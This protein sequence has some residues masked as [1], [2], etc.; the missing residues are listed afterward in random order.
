MKHLLIALVMLISVSVILDPSRTAAD[1]VW[2][3]DVSGGSSFTMGC[4]EEPSAPLNISL[5]AETSLNVNALTVSWEP[6]ETT[7]EIAQ[8]EYKLDIWGDGIR[9][10]S[11]EELPP[12]D[13]RRPAGERERVTASIPL[14]NYGS[15]WG[16]YYSFTSENLPEGTYTW[17]LFVRDQFGN[18]VST[19]LQ[20]VRIDRT[21][22]TVSLMVN[23]SPF[24]RIDD[25]IVI[26]NPETATYQLIAND[27]MPGSGIERTEYRVDGGA[28]TV[29]TSFTLPEGALVTLEYRSLDRAGNSSGIREEEIATD[30]EA[31]DAI[32]TLAA[33]TGFNTADLS[34]K[35]PG[36]NNPDNKVQNYEIFY[37]PA[38]SGGFDS[39]LTV[40]F[41]GSPGVE[42]SDQ[43]VTVTGLTPNTMYFAV[44]FST[45]F[46]GNRSGISNVAMF[47]TD[48]GR[49]Y[50]TDEIEFETVVYEGSVADKT[51]HIILRNKTAQALDMTGMSLKMQ[52][53]SGEATLP[54]SF[55]GVTI[56]GNGSVSVAAQ[57]ETL[58]LDPTKTIPDFDLPSESFTLTLFDVY[59]TLVDE[60]SAGAPEAIVS[61]NDVTKTV[62]FIVKSIS[63]FK[64]L[65]YMIT[66]KHD[67]TE[68]GISSTADL[69]GESTFTKDGIVLG[70]C[71]SGTCVLHEAITDLLLQV[72]LTD[73]E[74]NEVTVQDQL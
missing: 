28:W 65:K 47:T 57:G 72:I 31:P 25:R 49:A 6:S 3:P 69:N 73:E 42:G 40:P 70:T 68:E 22:P 55:T 45:D 61:L 18:T 53:A 32:T 26:F 19:G 71:S 64:T 20:V 5:P 63:P 52:T 50:S 67:G 27:P 10:P 1:P 39:A 34:W 14:I 54:V 48:P 24:T 16:N 9:S 21:A 7:C 8:L 44:I 66:Y 46:A 37:V 2:N 33:D 36:D 41:A 56:P 35:A 17:E 51:D 15:D 38:S 12:E 62:S 59:N 23:D 60:V 29:G 30:A 4:W 11:E 43:S 74:G 58:P 13:E